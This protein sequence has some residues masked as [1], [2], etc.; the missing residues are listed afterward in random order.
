LVTADV[1]LET[2]PWSEL[3]VYVE[4]PLNFP[5][6][7]TTEGPYAVLPAEITVPGPLDAVG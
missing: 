1:Q 7:T 5:E 4:N 3:S 2:V 6:P